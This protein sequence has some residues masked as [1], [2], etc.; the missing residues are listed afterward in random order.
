MNENALF[1]VNLFELLEEDDD[2]YENCCLIDGQSLDE[3]RIELKCKH[4]F[5]YLSLLN[6][7]QMQK[8]KNLLETQKIKSYEIKCP[9]C[10]SVHS[11]VLQYKSE[12]FEKKIKGVNWPPS[13]VLKFKSCAALLKSGKRKGELCGKSCVDEFCNQH[14]KTKKTSVNIKVG[15]TC[16]AIIKSGKRKGVVCGCKAKKNTSFCGRH[17]QKKTI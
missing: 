2:D 5:N 1:Y 10:R 7:I 16:T 17:I 4:K 6:E 8:K 13:K 3:N 11:G 15:P 9:Y 12:I 14:N